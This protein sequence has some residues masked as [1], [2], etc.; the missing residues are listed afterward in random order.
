M[1]ETAPVRY[2]ARYGNPGNGPFDMEPWTWRPMADRDAATKLA[3][4]WAYATVETET[5]PAHAF[6]AGVGLKCAVCDQIAGQPIHSPE[7][8]EAPE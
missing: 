7:P 8:D 4:G 3:T 6:H 5:I 2:Y 1:T